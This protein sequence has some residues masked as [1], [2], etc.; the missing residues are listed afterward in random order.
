MSDLILIVDDSELI[1]G[2][3]EMI[4]AQMGYRTA[5]ALTFEEVPALVAADPPK[6]ILSDLNMPDVPGGDTVA[7]LRAIAPLKD[8]PIVLISGVDQGELEDLAR[9]RGAQGAISK[10]AGLPGMMAQLGPL[11]ESL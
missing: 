3:L 8:I 6:V 11:L 10:D 2:M 7:A 5:L 9:Q 1:L 4:C